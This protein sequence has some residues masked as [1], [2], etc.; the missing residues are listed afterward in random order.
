MND[1]QKN[2]SLTQKIDMSDSFDIGSI[3]KNLAP[4]ILCNTDKIA[5]YLSKDFSL[6]KSVDFSELEEVSFEE[7]GTVLN[8]GRRGKA[9]GILNIP[10]FTVTL[11]HI[12][13]GA[14]F[15]T[16][17]HEQVE[18]VL[19]LHGQMVMVTLENE[20]ETSFMCRAGDSITLESMVP[21][22]AIFP[23]ESWIL[24]ITLPATKDFPE[25]ALTELQEKINN[26][27][28]RK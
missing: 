26:A 2:L 3:S 4:D 9:Y 24:V 8:M 5:A 14:K 22:N 10:S 19:I 1:D 23:E 11:S 6:D 25:G 18:V 13:K 17:H 28:K 27:I 20:K 21:H 7:G 12:S 16:H 15:E